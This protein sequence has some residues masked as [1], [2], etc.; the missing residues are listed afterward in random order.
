MIE[1]AT[2]QNLTPPI[3]I[4]ANK[5]VVGLAAV[6]VS[7]YAINEQLQDRRA[8]KERERIQR[9]RQDNID[10]L[11][12]RIEGAQRKKKEKGGMEGF[13]DVLHEM[14][15]SEGVW[16]RVEDILYDLILKVGE[17]GKPLRN[18]NRAFLNL[19]LMSTEYGKEDI[20]LATALA[21]GDEKLVTRIVELYDK[22]QLGIGLNKFT[23]ESINGITRTLESIDKPDISNE[24]LKLFVSLA[25]YEPDFVSGT[26][27][28]AFSKYGDEF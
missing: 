7:A 3:Y 18:S 8:R 11:Q 16:S 23:P 9:Q 1:C 2:D 15:F 24:C 17:D 6:G 13:A 20:M 21:L 5:A 4:M 19:P 25:V 28:L 26:P 22:H 27:K 10:S 12:M 14:Q